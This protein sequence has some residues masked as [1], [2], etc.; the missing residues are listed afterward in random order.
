MKHRIYDVGTEVQ[1]K[2]GRVKKKLRDGSWITRGRFIYMNKL[3]KHLDHLDRVFHINGDVSD[4]NPRNL[5]AIRFS[6]NRYTLR[7]S[8]VLW[9]PRPPK[10][11][12]K[13]VDTYR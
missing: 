10:N 12:P 13:K 5:V 1:E 9:E 4:D 6:G 2:S 3:G 8:R 11:L 7:T